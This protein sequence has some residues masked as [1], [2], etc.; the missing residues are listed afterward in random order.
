MTRCPERRAG[1]IGEGAAHSTV[2]QEQ[3]AWWTN[4]HVI[5]QYRIIGVDAELSELLSDE[6]KRRRLERSDHG[7]Y[8]PRISR[9]ISYASAR[10]PCVFANCSQ[11]IQRPSAG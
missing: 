4:N 7:A 2:K 5:R 11:L 6:D 9:M 1:V 3:G 8:L 10:R